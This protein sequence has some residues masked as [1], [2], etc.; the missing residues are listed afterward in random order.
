MKK[1]YTHQKALEAQKEH[2]AHK[3]QK[4]PKSTKSIKTQQSKSKKTQISKQKFKMCLRT[5]K[6]K[7]VTY[8]R[9]YACEEKNKKVSTME[10]L[11][12]LN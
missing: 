1:F 11:I 3:A 7:K 12:P 5:S 8:L 6:G 2:K 4:A 10:M 9:F